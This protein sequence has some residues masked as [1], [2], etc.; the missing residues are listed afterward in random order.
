MLKLF[1]ISNV[2]SGTRS[3]FFSSMVKRIVRGVEMKLYLSS[4][5]NKTDLKNFNVYEL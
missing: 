5:I 4:K 2:F 3:G 1:V